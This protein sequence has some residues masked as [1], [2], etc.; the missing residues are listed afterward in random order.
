MLGGN[1]YKYLL[2]LNVFCLS[3]FA[4]DGDVLGEELSKTIGQ[5]VY[6]PNFFGMILGL[7]LVVGLIY[8]TG[9][10]Y[11]KLL[12]VNIKSKSLSNNEI[13]ILSTTSL[14]QGRNLH[15]IKVDSKRLLV[16]S[17]QNNINL[18]KEL[19]NLKDGVEGGSEYG[20]NS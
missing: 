20:K 3:V 15:I 5:N 11:Q 13:D 18:I 7:F 17:T 4:Q 19:D 10:V 6:E 14:G 1:L 2:F 16:G 12:K 8:L 9:F